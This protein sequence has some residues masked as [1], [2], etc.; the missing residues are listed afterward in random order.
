MLWLI[1]CKDKPETAAARAE[2]LSPHREYLASQKP[3]LVLA[4]ATLSDDGESMTGSCFVLNV[5]TRAEA[6]QFS[7]GDPFTQAG[8]FAEVNITRM[9][10]GQWNPEAADDA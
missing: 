6:E 3:I 9:R 2:H 4:G 1:T 5:S 7:A 8:I 10:K